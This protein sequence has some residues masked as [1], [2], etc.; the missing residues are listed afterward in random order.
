MFITYVFR[1]AN[2]SRF[3]GSNGVLKADHHYSFPSSFQ[4]F[5]GFPSIPAWFQSSM[6]PCFSP[7]GTSKI[8][9]GRATRP[10]NFSMSAPAR[11]IWIRST[12]R[13]ER[14]SSISG[15]LIRG[16]NPSSNEAHSSLAD[17]V[18][19]MEKWRG[20]LA[21][22]FSSPAPFS[23]LK[24]ESER[25]TVNQG[26]FH[27]RKHGGAQKGP[28][29]LIPSEPWLRHGTRERDGTGSSAIRHPRQVQWSSRLFTTWEASVS[30]L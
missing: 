1:P 4:S 10:C 19:Y 23:G 29:W 8:P 17:R 2:L 12:R 11:L 16:V 28:R 18:E 6:R 13:E 27:D 5:C 25:I 7:Y 22:G 30:T 20:Y 15:T 26:M 9:M 14:W 21:A 24:N 3:F